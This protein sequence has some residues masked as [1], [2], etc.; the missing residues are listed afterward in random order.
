MFTVRTI[1]VSGRKVETAVYDGASAGPES[2]QASKALAAFLAARPAEFREKLTFLEHEAEL[3][4]TAGP[5]GVALASIYGPAAAY[6]MG[7][8]LAGIDEEADQMMLDAWK[9]NVLKPVFAQDAARFVHAPE[10]P[11]LINLVFPAADQLGASVQLTAAALAAAYFRS[12]PVAA[13]P[14]AR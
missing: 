3:E 6:S 10:R 1:S 11:V 2:E 12:R 14:W 8:L 9:E 4:W 13:A 7:I 5:E